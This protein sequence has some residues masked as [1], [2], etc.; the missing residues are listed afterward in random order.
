M[1]IVS[2]DYDDLRR[3]SGRGAAL[4]QSL[5]AGVNI[6]VVSSLGRWAITWFVL[7]CL[8]SNWP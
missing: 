3:K 7:T 8:V 2:C 5:R 1:D 4:A 6:V